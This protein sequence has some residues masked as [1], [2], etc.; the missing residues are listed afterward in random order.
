MNETLVLALEVS[1]AA[2]GLIAALIFVCTYHTGIYKSFKKPVK[3]MGVIG[4]V[5]VVSGESHGDEST[6]GYYVI[7]YSYTDNGGVQRTNTFKWQQNVGNTGD[8]IA[9]HCDSQ[10]PQNSIADCQLKYG[11]NLWWKV[12]IAL[13]AIILPAVIIVIL[14]D[15]R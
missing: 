9:L 2:I 12:L 15:R 1:G 4:E 7:T 14:F 3:T 6:R 5:R 8:K 13:A 10:N 11:K